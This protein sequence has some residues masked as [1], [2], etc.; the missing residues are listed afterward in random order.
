MARIRMMKGGRARIMSLFAML[1]SS[2]P[3]KRNRGQKSK[4]VRA[5]RKANKV[6]R[7]ARRVNRMGR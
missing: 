1:F 2:R 6:A 3:L 7:R 4:A 5:R